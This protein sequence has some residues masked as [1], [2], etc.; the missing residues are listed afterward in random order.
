MQS[1][2]GSPVTLGRRSASWSQL[3]RVAMRSAGSVGTVRSQGCAR[4][5]APS[6]S[7]VVLLTAAVS[8]PVGGG[9]P[10]GD[11]GV[12]AV[13]AGFV[14][15]ECRSGGVPDPLFDGSPESRLPG[16]VVVVLVDGA[17]SDL[18]RLV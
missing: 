4:R 15:G 14:G 6:A 8:A 18:D 11:P 12:V 13:V 2:A 7:T 9:D 10:G 3:T 16:V 5:G 1:T 17:A